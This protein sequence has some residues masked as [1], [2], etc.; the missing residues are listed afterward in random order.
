MVQNWFAQRMC[1]TVAFSGVRGVLRV[2][3][4]P[5]P[6]PCPFPFHRGVLH[7][8]HRDVLPSFLLLRLERRFLLIPFLLRDVHRGVHR[9]VRGPE[10]QLD[11]HQE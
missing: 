11:N 3:D 9:D 2:R 4:D 10:L 8:V 6:S 5:F 7:D 1:G